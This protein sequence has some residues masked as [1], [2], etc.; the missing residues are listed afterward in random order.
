MVK[1]VAPGQLNH[2]PM[3]DF[4]KAGVVPW[5]GQPRALFLAIF[6]PCAFRDNFVIEKNSEFF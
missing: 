3:P 4:T 6:V 2:G 5:L 1:N